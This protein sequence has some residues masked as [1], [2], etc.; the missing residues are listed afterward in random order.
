M[1]RSNSAKVAGTCS[2]IRLSGRWCAGRTTLPL[3]RTRPWLPRQH[4]GD[5]GEQ[6]GQRPVEPI[7][8]VASEGVAVAEVGEAR[9][10]LGLLLEQPGDAVSDVL[11]VE[12]LVAALTLRFP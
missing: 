1:L 8:G 5:D 12:S 2:C 7:H 4:L 10:Q 11:A 6:V 3:S 9:G